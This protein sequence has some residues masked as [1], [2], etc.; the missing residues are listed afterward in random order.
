MIDEE[1]RIEASKERA[2][3]EDKKRRD[4]TLARFRFPEGAR[5][6]IRDA[7][8]QFIDKELDAIEREYPAIFAQFS[9]DELEG[10]SDEDA[11]GFVRMVVDG[12]A[13]A[14]AEGG[15]KAEAAMA[16]LVADKDAMSS[17]TKEFRETAGLEPKE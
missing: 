12:V 7:Y 13:G 5:K 1:A 16:K 15:Q 17:L 2:A 4:K 14:L 11:S 3:E 10:L 6:R 8:L 9:T